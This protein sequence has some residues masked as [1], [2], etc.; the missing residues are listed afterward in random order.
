METTDR[1][2]EIAEEARHRLEGT[3]ATV[4]R[5][6][7]PKALSR[8]LADRAKDKVRDAAEDVL[9]T[10]KARP[11]L[12]ASVAAA[13]AFLLLRKPIKS[14]VKLVSKEKNHG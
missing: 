6:F 8:E 10:A 7:H 5:R 12:I 1:H 13:A 4:K 14:A 9:E 11:A 3:V 2:R